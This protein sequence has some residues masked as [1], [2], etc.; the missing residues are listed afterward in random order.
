MMNSQGPVYIHCT[1]GK[2]RT[3]FVCVLLEALAGTS[4]DEMR[5]DFMESY[6]NYF[7]VDQV[8]T[9]EKYN[10]IV[11]LYFNDYIR[12]LLRSDEIGPTENVNYSDDAAR[13]LIM[14]GM[15][16]KE[17]QQLKVFLTE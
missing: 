3:G 16:E 8:N 9:P 11:E 10:A 2:E 6:R 14:G 7:A 12:G 1:E 4:Y 17:V 13:Y 5:E 15:T